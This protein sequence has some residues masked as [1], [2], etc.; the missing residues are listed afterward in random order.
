VADWFPPLADEEPLL[1]ELRR[2]VVLRIV[3]AGGEPERL[4][5]ISPVA[6]VRSA[7]VSARDLVRGELKLVS[8]PDIYF[9]IVEAIESPRTS[10]SRIAEVVGKDTSLSAKLLRIVNSS[11]YG[12]PSRIESITRAITIIGADELSTLALGVSTI[13]VFRDVPEGFVTMRSFWR[14]S[15]TVGVFA[16]LLAARGNARQ[17][18]RLFTAGLL[19]DLGRLLMLRKIPFTMTQALALARG[20]K[21]SL[22]EAEQELLGFDHSVVGGLLLSEWNLPVGLSSAVR[23]HHA[24]MIASEPLPP[25]AVHLADLLAL[26]LRSGSSGGYRVPAPEPEAIRLLGLSPN[27]LGPLIL[28]AERQ[29]REIEQVFLEGERNG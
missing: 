22:P 25:S 4:A 8:L 9:R 14:H 15:I 12:F 17:D 20:R 10:A 24:P 16:R 27:A 18:E 7:P 28:Q 5:P 29:V 3:G 21:I 13:Q 2:L 11:F 19:H 26:A 6:R 1:T 23:H